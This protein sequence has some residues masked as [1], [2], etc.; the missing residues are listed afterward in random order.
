MLK[1]ERDYLRSCRRGFLAT[2]AKG[3]PTVVPVCF[4]L[5]GDVIY[6]AIDGK[7]KGTR[8]ARLSNISSNPSVAFLVDNYSEDW[9]ELSYLLIHGDAKVV[10]EET[11]AEVARNL[12][13]ER[14]PQYG[15]LKLDGC[16]VLAISVRESKFWAFGKPSKASTS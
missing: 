8:L 11:Q 1:R 5:K 16:P 15:W 2:S 7:P 13:R 12:L 6:T 3:R 9:R 4:C 10:K 14:Y